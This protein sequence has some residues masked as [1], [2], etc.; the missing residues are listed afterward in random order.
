MKS[1][2]DAAKAAEHVWPDMASSEAA[3]E[4]GYGASALAR[5]SNNLFGLKQRSH[6]IYGSVMMPTREFLNGLWTEVNV[7][8]VKYDTLAECFE[9]RMETLTRLRNV[10][11][12]YDAALKAADPVTYIFQVSASWSTDPLRSQKCLD[13]YMTY[14]KYV[15]PVAPQPVAWPNQ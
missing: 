1:V 7:E 3:L 2:A 13:I 4:S 12:H 11:P 5:E 14:T 15:P 8:F 10:Y 9:D 6:P